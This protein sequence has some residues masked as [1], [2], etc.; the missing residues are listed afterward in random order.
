MHFSI[1]LNMG[2]LAVYPKLEP[3]LQIDLY[4]ITRKGGEFW[5]Q[6]EEVF[7]TD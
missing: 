7:Y 3:G 1:G 4:S 6:L 2:R 5:M